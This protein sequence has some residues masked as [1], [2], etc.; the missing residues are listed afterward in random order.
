[1][2]EDTPEPSLKAIFGMKLTGVELSDDAG[3][4]ASLAV[5]FMDDWQ[6]V[7]STD[8]EWGHFA[9]MAAIHQTGYLGEWLVDVDD[10]ADFNE[11]LGTHAGRW[12]RDASMASARWGIDPGLLNAA[13]SGAM[14]SLADQGMV[15]VT[16]P[17]LAIAAIAPFVRFP[18]GPA[19]QTPP[20]GLRDPQQLYDVAAAA[21]ASAA[22][23]GGL[24]V[25]ADEPSIG[26]PTSR[27][28][29][30]APELANRMAAAFEAPFA[31]LTAVTFDESVPEWDAEFVRNTLQQ[32]ALWRQRDDANPQILELLV[33]DVVKRLH[34]RLTN[35]DA[36]RVSLLELGADESVAA[37]VAE[38]TSAALTHIAQLGQ[39]DPVE[40]G[41]RIDQIAD[42]AEGLAQA[43]ANGLSAVESGEAAGER[44]G[45]VRMAIVE[46]VAG[47]AV[48]VAISALATFSGDHWSQ[49]QLGLIA[50]WNTVRSIWP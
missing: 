42:E 35:T 48:S 33:A 47:G 46:G 45:R 38:R 44:T 36:L 10:G 39:P 27:P 30:L 31:A 17:H 16:V 6:P 32:I 19:P 2:T 14:R 8:P 22:N 49:I 21:I 13:T 24:Q 40:D 34:E 12:V 7:N 4:V 18:S 23:S 43:A 1:M 9:V 20:H 50:A 5:R 29:T 25:I 3:W 41:H 11:A 37:D 15:T 26:A 28:A